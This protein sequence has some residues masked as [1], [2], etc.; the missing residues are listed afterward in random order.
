MM[1]PSR[2]PIQK[3]SRQI[4]RS[5]GAADRIECR[6]DSPRLGTCFPGADAATQIGAGGADTSAGRRPVP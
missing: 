4:V 6:E 1:L 5:R 3:F 2:Q